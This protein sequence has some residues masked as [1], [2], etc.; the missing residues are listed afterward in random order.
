MSMFYFL[1]AV[2]FA[3]MH[4]ETRTVFY[5]IT[6]PFCCFYSKLFIIW[7]YEFTRNSTH[8][9]PYSYILIHKQSLNV[10]AS[11][12]SSDINVHGNL[13]L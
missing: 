3:T 11:Y 13:F 5:H 2:I 12:C 10:K 7:G 1:N 4:C 6:K 8:A 9:K